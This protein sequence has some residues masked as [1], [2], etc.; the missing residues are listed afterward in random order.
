MVK[1]LKGLSSVYNGLSSKNSETFYFLTDTAELYLGSDKI[2]SHSELT[3][4]LAKVATNESEISKLKTK[5]DNLVGGES[6]SIDSMI[7][8]AIGELRTELTGAINSA[9]TDLSS[10]ISSSVS[11]SEET[12]REEM[13]AYE[14][15]VKKLDTPE[16]G[17]FASYEIKQNG[18]KVGATINVPKDIALKTGSLVDIEGVKNLQLILND[19]DETKINIPVNELVDAYVTGSEEGADVTIA[20]SGDNKITATLSSAIKS[21]LTKANSALQKSDITTGATDGTIKVAGEEVAVKGLGSAAFEDKGAFD[22]FGAG[23]SAAATMKTEANKYT[24]DEIAKLGDLAKMNKSALD[25]AYDAKGAAD[26][27]KMEANAYTN[28]ALEWG[29]IEN[30]DI[31]MPGV[32]PDPSPSDGGEVGRN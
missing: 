18:T 9:K 21:S 3:D 14:I 11:A 32:S 20:V 13:E 29:T 30:D 25:A 4:A 19:E 6:G 27:A 5:L 22:P 17:F 28:S 15:D 1:F 26:I 7:E 24:D 16:D 2:S 31:V 23:A 12:L 8:S 10:E